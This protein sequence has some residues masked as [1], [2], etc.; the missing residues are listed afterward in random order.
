MKDRL[1]E[2]VEQVRLSDTDLAASVQ[3]EPI[4]PSVLTTVR[5]ALLG[6]ETHYTSRPGIPELRQRLAEEVQ[7]LGGP[8]YDSDAIVVTNSERE[9]LY[10]VLLAMR[11]ELGEVLVSAADTSR[12]VRLF[13]LCQL[14]PIPVTRPPVSTPLTRLIYREW[15][16]NRDEHESL[17]IL[18]SGTKQSV[19]QGI[20]DVVD[21]V[22][23]GAR[24]GKAPTDFPPLTV[25]Q[26]ILIGNLESLRGMES[27]G[28]GFIAGPKKAI[29][30]IRTWKQALSIC[31]SAPSQRAA[32]AAIDLSIRDA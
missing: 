16:G 8:S 29:G 9:A 14:C 13:R 4:P 11:F 6:G 1:A 7:R 21:I 32:I 23:M 28:L 27:F 12:H 30:P 26:T 3:V 20:V 18:A 25:D 2:R 15:P 24:L 17:C 31:T 5:T 22:D 19:S 10:V